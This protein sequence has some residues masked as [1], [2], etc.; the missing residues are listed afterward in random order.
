MFGKLKKFKLK[1]LVISLTVSAIISTLVVGIFGYFKMG[2][3]NRQVG[4]MYADYLVPVFDIGN[5]SSNFYQIKAADISFKLDKTIDFPANIKTNRDNID[6]YLKDYEKIAMD[7]REKKDLSN[8]K[9]GYSFFSNMWDNKG[10]GNASQDIISQIQTQETKI[11][12]SLSD[13]QAYSKEIALKNKKICD[14]AYKST[15]RIM[16]II[17]IL[18]LAVFTLIAYMIIL[19]I[20]KSSKEMITNLKQIAKGDFTVKLDCNSNSEFGFMNSSLQDT[21]VNVSDMIKNVKDSVNNVNLQAMNLSSVSEEMAASSENATKSI[22]EVSKSNE[23]QSG[24]LLD[25]N[26]ELNEFGN[27]IEKIVDAMKTIDF[28]SRNINTMAMDSDVKLEVLVKSINDL[29]ASFKDFTEKTNALGVKISKIND[30]TSYINNISEQTN[31][32]ALNASIEAARAGEH[33]RGFSVVAEEIRKLAEESKGSTQSISELTAGI[34]ND[35]SKIMT[36]T[37]SMNNKLNEQT[38]VIETSLESFKLII[39]A[40]EVVL[41]EIDEVAESVSDLDKEKNNITM[42]VSNTSSLA[43]EISSASEE[44]AASSEELS[45]STNE[46][47]K[48]ASILNNVT[49]EVIVSVSKFKL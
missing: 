49:K 15:E 1:N 25:I 44:I 22:Q 37:N 9:E 13:L 5:I 31:L 35:T 45:N 46:V 29:I 41:P 17:F 6:K 42:K 27:R 2:A 47:A 43:E 24:N 30:I 19:V 20:D 32:L 26:S 12:K 11:D 23:A 36:M 8:F 48:S 33:G 28:N 21:I 18:S 38:K 4:D 16:L 40:V 34:E 7:E 10:A 3:L 39:S 14:A